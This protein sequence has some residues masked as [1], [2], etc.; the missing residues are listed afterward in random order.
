MGKNGCAI[1][2]S[3]LRDLSFQITGA[4]TVS[5][6]A[7]YIQFDGTTTAIGEQNTVL[8]PNTTYY[9]QI[10]PT[11]SLVYSTSNFEPPNIPLAI[12]TTDGTS[13][14]TI[15]DQRAWLSSSGGNGI[16][17]VSQL[18]DLRVSDGGGLL[19]NINSGSWTVGDEVFTRTDLTSIAIADNTIDS[20]YAIADRTQHGS[21]YVVLGSSLSEIPRT[22]I[23]LATFQTISGSIFSL[24]DKRTWLKSSQPTDLLPTTLTQQTL[25]LQVK[26]GLINVNN[27]IVRFPSTQIALTNNADNYVEID[28]AGTLSKNTS[29]YT[30]GRL[31]VAKVTTASGS[32]TTIRDDRAFVTLASIPST[33]QA[34]PSNPTGTTDTTGKMMGLAGT[35]TPVS[36]GKI[37]I[38]ISG[39]IANDTIADGAAVQI[40][41]GT[42]TAP[43]NADALTGTAVGGLVSSTNPDI[44][45]ATLNVPFS[46]NAI[47][48]GLTPGTAYWIDT[49]LKAITGG[50]ATISNVSISVIEV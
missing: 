30:V 21:A 41:Y 47:V 46:L 8:L 14:T 28:S 11:G 48:T 29:S 31:P 33:S 34:T 2:V 22:A 42:G 15:E 20:V 36:T 40:R 19:I 23:L 16:L 9:A 37:L 49:G 39:D 3:R 6:Y 45:L 44:A 18:K 26:A 7:G 50:T 5:P 35:I 27:N 10:D 1:P 12:I 13:V 4:L 43:A 32:I 24:T 25:N 17:T 38:V